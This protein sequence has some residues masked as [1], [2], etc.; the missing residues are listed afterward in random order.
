MKF[1]TRHG[2]ALLLAAVLVVGVF[3]YTAAA[4]TKETF[5]DSRDGYKY[6]TVKIGG[7]TWMAQ[8]LNYQTGSSWCYGGDNSN[9]AKY[10]RL[11]DWN[12]AKAVC[13]TGF[14]LPSRQ[15]W[16]SLAKA[17]GGTGDY[18]DGG[19]AGKKLKARS[20]WTDNGNGTDAY[21]FS[22]LPGGY[23]DI[24]DGSFDM[25]GGLGYWWTA[26]EYS[27]GK[28]YYRGM[29]DNYGDVHEVYADKGNGFS[30]RCIAD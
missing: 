29:S 20:G 10:G 16:V 13:P 22:A 21:G 17:A 15:E 9:C 26:T 14:H 30:V 28:A 8:N 1:F 12:T 5:T 18:G 19:T 11:Y 6:K 2:R 25:V 7:K 4:Q 3:V 24:A 27:S 23:R